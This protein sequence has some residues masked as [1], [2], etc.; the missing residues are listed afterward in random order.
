MLPT[1]AFHSH[2]RPRPP[3]T[4]SGVRA[5][6]SSSPPTRRLAARCGSW[7]QVYGC[8]GAAAAA[9]AVTAAEVAGSTGSTSARSSPNL[10]RF[11]NNASSASEDEAAADE[12]GGGDPSRPRRSGSQRRGSF[13]A[14][15]RWAVA[16]ARLRNSSAAG[17][18]GAGFSTEGLLQAG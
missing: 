14:F 1:S 12:A 3:T 2:P 4:A 9:A 7:A 6:P 18:G 15:D 13:N 10:F 17:A 5:R 8:D 11:G 16:K